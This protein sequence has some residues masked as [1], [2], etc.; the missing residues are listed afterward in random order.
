MKYLLLGKI[1]LQKKVTKKSNNIYLIF[2]SG[3]V[4]YQ[5]YY[6]IN[7]TGYF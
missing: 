1:S 7:N 5:N 2:K 4:N 3:F 6:F